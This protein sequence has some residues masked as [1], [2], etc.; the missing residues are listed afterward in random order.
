MTVE[1][2]LEEAELLISLLTGAEGAFMV[3]NP[4]LVTALEDL[5]PWRTALLR[6]YLRE[7][8]SVGADPLPR[9]HEE[10]TK[11]R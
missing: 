8:I 5:R 3:A 9:P 6:T 11:E 10:E 2:T 7:R 4:P 1:L